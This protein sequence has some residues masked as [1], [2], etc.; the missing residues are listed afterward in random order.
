MTLKFLSL[1]LTCDSTHIFFNTNKCLITLWETLLEPLAVSLLQVCSKNSLSL[2]LLSFFPFSLSCNLSSKANFCFA[3]VLPS[4]FCAKE[5]E[6]EKERER[7]RVRVCVCPCARAYACRHTKIHAHAH[8]DDCLYYYTKRFSTHD[9][10]SMRSNPFLRLLVVL[11]SHLLNFF[12]GRRKF[13][14]EQSS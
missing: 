14:K 2:S 10:G 12:L 6:G 9:W 13:V 4:L 7:E 3:K 5:G 11:R 1:S 8:D